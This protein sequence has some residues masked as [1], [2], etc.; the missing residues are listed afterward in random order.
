MEVDGTK[1]ISVGQG[2]YGSI[3]PSRGSGDYR[4]GATLLSVDV[5]GVASVYG[6]AAGGGQCLAVAENQV[7][8][9][10]NLYAAANGDIVLHCVIRLDASNTYR[11]GS[12]LDVGGHIRRVL[13]K[14]L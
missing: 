11:R 14:A 2:S 7:Y 12:C 3:V 10:K 13:D 8:R 4:A 1:S 9:A 5:Q 6:D